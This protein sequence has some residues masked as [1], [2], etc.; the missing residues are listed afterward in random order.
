MALGGVPVKRW[1][2]RVYTEKRPRSGTEVIVLALLVGVP[3]TWWLFYIAAR[4]IWQAVL[5]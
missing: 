3:L 4:A 1:N 2:P 5:G